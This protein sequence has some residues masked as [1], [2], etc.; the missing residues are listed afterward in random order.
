[1]TIILS[2]GLI[3]SSYS[4]RCYYHGCTKCYVNARNR[5][6]SIPLSAM[7]KRTLKQES[8]LRKKGYNLHIM[9]EHDFESVLASNH[10]AAKNVK[11]MDIQQRL[12][13]R[14]LHYYICN[15]L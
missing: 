3:M 11:A 13:P 4:Y 5:R 6:T 2:Y 15:T 1:M 14:Y 9:W 12:N 8:E 10:A 7:N